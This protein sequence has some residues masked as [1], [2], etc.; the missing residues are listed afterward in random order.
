MSEPF[1][2]LIVPAYHPAQELPDLIERMLGVDP[3][4][5][6]AAVVVDD[7]NE[8]EWQ[9]IFAAV[10]R[11]ERATVARRPT[12]GGKGAALKTGIAK[13]LET[14]PDIAGIVT[15]DADG[16]HAP[17]DVARVG[18]ALADSPNH[19][20]LG[21]RRFGPEVPFRSRVG[22]EITR[23]VFRWAT[24]AW[25][26]DTQTGLRGWPREL[27]RRS[28]STPG[29]GFEYELQALLDT[30]DAPRI[31]I[32]VETIYANENRLSNFRPLR[33]SFRIYRV[34]LRHALRRP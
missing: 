15:A 3:S 5:F 26:M 32:P 1:L 9:P 10:T 11:V 16:Q 6:R 27:V 20:V 7:G 22:N 8:P 21:G 2:A 4:L 14:W 24:G 19:L 13:V 29:S 12:N 17:A 33:D 25:L 30:L 18:R 34:L 31:E 23:T 28:L